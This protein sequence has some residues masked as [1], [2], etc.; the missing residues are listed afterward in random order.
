MAQTTNI[1]FFCFSVL[2]FLNSFPIL[3]ANNPKRHRLHMCSN[4]SGL[5]PSRSQ[6]TVLREPLLPLHELPGTLS[7]PCFFFTPPQ[8][9]LYSFLLHFFFFFVSCRLIRLIC[10]FIWLQ[11]KL[12]MQKECE[13]PPPPLES[14][15]FWTEISDSVSHRF[16]F[17]PDGRLSVSRIYYISLQVPLIFPLSLFL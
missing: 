16:Q 8:Y 10:L 13:K 7:N 11:E 1:P 5:M 17:G 3:M 4:H 9:F 6:V 2:A 14:P 12:K 15:L